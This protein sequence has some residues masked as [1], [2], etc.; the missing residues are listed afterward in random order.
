MTTYQYGLTNISFSA[1]R[2]TLCPEGYLF[3]EE[4]P[5]DRPRSENHRRLEWV[6]N[7]VKIKIKVLAFLKNWPLNFLSLL[8]NV[9]TTYI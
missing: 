2:L 8:Q 4:T 7:I 3:N 1:N 5:S 6:L 9:A